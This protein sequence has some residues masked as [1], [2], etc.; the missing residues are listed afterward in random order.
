MNE[1]F[2]EERR[3]EK[4]ESEEEKEFWLLGKSIL[5]YLKNID[6]KLQILI[7]NQGVQSLQFIQLGDNMA[8]V[9]QFLIGLT[10]GATS[11]FQIVPV[12]ANGNA[13]ALDA[14]STLSYTSNDPNVTVSADPADPTGLTMLAVTAA[15]ITAPSVNL[16]ASAS[17]QKNGNTPTTGQ[18][19]VSVLAAVAGGAK[20]LILN[21]LS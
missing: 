14:G 15:G 11:K 12:D 21:Q 2:M 13:I 10:P 3:E 1:E 6:D 16:S 8:G 9:T 5:R 19:A 18:V 7:G 20:S 4:R 17:L